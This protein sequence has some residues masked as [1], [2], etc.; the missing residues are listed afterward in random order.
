MT[1]QVLL[2]AAVVTTWLVGYTLWRLGISEREALQ[3]RADTRPDEVVARADAEW[4]HR[5]RQTRP[6]QWMGR[7]LVRA[8]LG[9]RVLDAW[10]ALV[11]ITV[12]AFVV[13][14]RYVTW[15]VALVVGIGIARACLLFLD[16]KEQQRREAFIAQLPQVARVLSNA[17]SAGLALRSAIR[18]ASEDIGP[19]A[20]LELGHLSERLSVGTGIAEAMEEMHDRL[21]SRELSLLTR[22]LVIQARAGGAV[23]TALR[24]MSET[25]EARKE[26]RREIRTILSGVVYTSWIVLFIGVGAVLAMNAIAP[27]T[28]DRLTSTLMGQAVIAVSAVLFALGF[29]LI[30]RTIRIEV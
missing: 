22:T 17:T 7:R 5:L 27:G 15:W 11:A 8:G 2:L 14:D 3:N 12:L 24:D 21:P 23:V 26:L 13:A 9:W 4:D 30:R 20:G 25:L 29:L 1:R 28:L 18:L 16:R 10:A 6:G 19:P